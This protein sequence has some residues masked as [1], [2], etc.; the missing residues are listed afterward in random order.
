VQGNGTTIEVLH[1]TPGSSPARLVQDANLKGCAA[2][3]MDP[4]ADPW[5]TAYSANLAPYYTPSG[6][7][8]STLS[9]GTWDGPWGE[10]YAPAFGSGTAAFIVSNATAGTIVRVTPGA[11]PTFD[12]IISGF[13]LN[14]GAAPGNILGAAGL[15]YD[16][17]SNTLF[18]VDSNLDR[19]LAFAG[20]STMASNA[21]A[22]TADGFSGPSADLARVVFVGPP[23]NAPLSSAELFNGD[24]IVANTGD[25]NLL[26]ISQSGQLNG[27]QNLDPAGA[28]G[29][30][31]GL[32]VSGTTAATTKIYF[33][34]D[35]DNTVKVL[36]VP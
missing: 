27:V 31:F 2:I 20:F 23:L 12:T 1:P 18:V 4:S 3:A 21:I 8:I 28:V 35:N 36:T 33:N 26:E 6:T 32:A 9:T 19:V 24:L 10:T 22:V 16:L 14:T 15:T 30:L 11:T 34:D 5:A 29:A 17:K 7:L 25:N 13:S